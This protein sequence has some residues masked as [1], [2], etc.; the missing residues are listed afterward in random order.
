MANQLSDEEAAV[1]S[2]VCRINHLLQ[3]WTHQFRAGEKQRIALARLLVSAPRLLL[4]DE[5]FSNLDAIHKNILKS[6]IHAIADDLKLTC[7]LV[8]HDPADVLS[9]A[10][11]I[12]VLQDGALIQQGT[13]EDVYKQPV[14]EYARLV[15]QI[16]PA[17]PRAGKSVFAVCR[18]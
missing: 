13:P 6:V 8:S 2:E 17:A 12:L 9:W 15:W 16:Q 11:E 7:L 10:D 4:L 18:H 1:I 3:R 14:S 5:P